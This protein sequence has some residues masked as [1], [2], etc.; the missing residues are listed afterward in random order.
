VI[1]VPEFTVKLAALFE[2]N[3]TAVAPVKA[4]PVTVTD[5]PPPGV[6]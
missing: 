1:E 5:V 6:P 2:P 4:V 3:L